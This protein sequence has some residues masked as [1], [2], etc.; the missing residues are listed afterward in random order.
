MPQRDRY[1]EK[2][3]WEEEQEKKEKGSSKILHRPRKIV[4]IAGTVR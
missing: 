4:V 3:K 2:K 1:K